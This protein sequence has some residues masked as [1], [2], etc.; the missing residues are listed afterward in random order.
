MWKHPVIKIPYPVLELH[1]LFL[2]IHIQFHL[3]VKSGFK[4]YLVFL[5]FIKIHARC[6][7]FP[8]Q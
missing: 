1:I 8:V 3:S 2:K 5:Y 7:A 4:P 6:S